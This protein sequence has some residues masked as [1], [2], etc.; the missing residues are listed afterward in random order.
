MSSTDFI[1]IMIEELQQQDPLDPQDTSKL[2]EQISSLRSIE[3]QT[4]LQ[5][6]LKA[7]VTQN[8]IA[9]AGNLIGKLVAGVDQTSTNTSGLVTA[10]RVTSDGVLLQL[11]NGSEMLM[12][13]VSGI[14]NLDALSGATN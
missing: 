14:S 6:Q 8:Q 7:L 10:V 11:D 12:D 4:S 13:N 2:M 9:A 5:D 1:K 3:S